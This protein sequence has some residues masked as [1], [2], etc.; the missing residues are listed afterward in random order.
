MHEAGGVGL[1]GPQVGLDWRI[2]VAN[3]TGE[4]GDDR[5]YVN[6]VLR[7]PTPRTE[8]CTEGCLS[9]PQVSAEVTR[10]VGITLEALDERGQPVT[11][12]AEGLEARVWQHEHDHLDGILI[13]DRMPPADRMANQRVLRDLEAR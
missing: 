6:P 4:P 11:R 7:D 2:F 12:T 10:P 8:P 3:V 1:A 5:V 13:I 9:L